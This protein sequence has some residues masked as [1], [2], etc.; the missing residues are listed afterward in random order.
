M[1]KREV[2]GLGWV[3]SGWGWASLGF[4]GCRGRVVGA[5]WPSLAFWI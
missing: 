2:Q 4:V 3:K 5:C 1:V